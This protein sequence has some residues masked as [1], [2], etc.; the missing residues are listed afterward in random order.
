M[1]R[2]SESTD[3]GRDESGELGRDE[4]RLLRRLRGPHGFFSLDEGAPDCCWKSAWWYD[5][6]D[7]AKGG[8]FT[9]SVVE[10]EVAEE[11]E[12]IRLRVSRAG[13]SCCRYAPSMV[14][15]L[16]RNGVAR[17][18]GLVEGPSSEPGKES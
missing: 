5:S 1:G 4:E 11:K 13:P 15:V 9:S 6:N 10:R 2:G 12:P 16:G 14:C 3:G 8:S 17:S 18:G 7:D